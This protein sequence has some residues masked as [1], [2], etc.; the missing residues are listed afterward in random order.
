MNP[1]C[2]CLFCA[3]QVWQ[4]A[5]QKR[6]VTF[7]YSHPPPSSITGTGRV[8]EVQPE[9][10]SWRQLQACCCGR[11]VSG[12]QGPWRLWVQLVWKETCQRP[13]CG[14]MFCFL[15][16]S[17][18]FLKSEKLLLGFSNVLSFQ[19]Y[20]PFEKKLFRGSYNILAKI[21]NTPFS[22][23]MPFFSCSE[24]TTVKILSWFLQLLCT[25]LFYFN[26][27]GDNTPIFPEAPSMVRVT[28]CEHTSRV[29]S[30]FGL[31]AEKAGL[32][33]S[34]AGYLPWCCM[35]GLPKH[36]PSLKQGASSRHQALCWCVWTP[37]FLWARTQLP[38]FSELL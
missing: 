11:S 29:T 7:L 18:K 9:L 38:P 13:Q 34:R 3:L 8:F 12:L 1:V 21:H 10:S 26:E 6:G 25:W 37:T 32:P 14:D 17:T 5:S 20:F 27:V 2:Q 23:Q 28:I 24:L 31:Q 4:Q 33:A 36:P 22:Y 19:K 35:S 15:G 16:L 30:T